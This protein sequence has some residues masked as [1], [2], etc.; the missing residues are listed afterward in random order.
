MEELASNIFYYLGLG[1][2]GTLF[3]ICVGV[4]VYAVNVMIDTA[5]SDKNTK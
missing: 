5:F 1:M 3:I 2:L 4:I